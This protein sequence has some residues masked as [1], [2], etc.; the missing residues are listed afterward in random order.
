ML[1]PSTSLTQ[2]KIPFSLT[3]YHIVRIHKHNTEL[4]V[5]GACQKYLNETTFSLM[6][7]YKIVTRDYHKNSSMFEQRLV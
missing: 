7:C 2:I 5:K 4:S 1:N 6:T 3:L